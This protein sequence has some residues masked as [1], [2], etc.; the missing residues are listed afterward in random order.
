[1]T[2]A[3]DEA[4]AVEHSRFG[5]VSQVDGYRV[6]PSGIVNLLQ[7][8]RT[9]GDE[10]RLIVGGTARF[11]IPFHAPWPQDIRLAM[12]HTVDIFLQFLIG[13]HRNVLDKIII[14]VHRREGVMTAIFSILCCLDEVA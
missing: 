11:G 9:D 13:V 10:L 1:M 2:A 8:F 7:T 12:P 6:A 3:K 14:A 5:V 4:L